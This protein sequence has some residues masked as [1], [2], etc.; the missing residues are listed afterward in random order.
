MIFHSLPNNESLDENVFEVQPTVSPLPFPMDDPTGQQDT[1][2]ATATG[3]CENRLSDATSE[4]QNQRSCRLTGMNARQRSEM[5]QANNTFFCSGYASP[6]SLSSQL[7]P[8]RPAF[9][10]PGLIGYAETW[11]KREIEEGRE[12]HRI[13]FQ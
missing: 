9:L 8:A 12:V 10:F 13:K 11:E 5:V 1:S 2:C 6:S 3:W 4:S 7:R